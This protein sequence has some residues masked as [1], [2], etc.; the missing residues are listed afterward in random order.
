VKVV[1][2]VLLVKNSFREVKQLVHPQAILP[3][4]LNGNVVPKDV[5]GNVLSFIVLYLGLFFAGTL[6]MAALGLDLM[7]A[8][9]AA[10]SCI[11]NIGPAFGTMGPTEN[12]AHVPALGKWVLSFLMVAGRLEIYTILILL[13]P[14]FWRR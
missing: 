12:Y 10:L 5:M 4:R 14:T 2:H 13:A 7:S 3:I 6:V 9:G 1:R 8:F 11:G